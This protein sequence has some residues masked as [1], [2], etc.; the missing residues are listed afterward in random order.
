MWD[1]SDLCG[2]LMPLAEKVLGDADKVVFAR[3]F[4]V[5]E[6][7]VPAHVNLCL[8]EKRV[9]TQEASKLGLESLLFISRFRE[10]HPR[11]ANKTTR[12]PSGCT[13]IRY[14]PCGCG[15]STPQQSAS[16]SMPSESEVGTKVQ[17]WLDGGCALLD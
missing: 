16:N 12:C 17:E 6:W 10:E 2:Y 13:A 8:R 5:N 9:T 11:E 14:Y 4:N 1:F 15:L 3:E 7:L